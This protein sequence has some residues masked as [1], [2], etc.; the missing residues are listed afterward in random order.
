MTTTLPTIKSF[1]CG[2][3]DEGENTELNI[4]IS[5]PDAL[6]ATSV[7]GHIAILC[8]Q[9][10]QAGRVPTQVSTGEPVPAAAPASTGPVDE[11]PLTGPSAA[12]VSTPS[13]DAKPAK[14]APSAVTTTRRTA[15]KTKAPAKKASP[16]KGGA[17][18]EAEAKAATKPA[19][20]AVPDKPAAAEPVAKAADPKVA[21]D[22]VDVPDEVKTAESFSKV[23]MWMAQNVGQ[24]FDAITARVQQ[25]RSQSPAIQRIDTD[26]AKVRERVERG[27]TVLISRGALKAA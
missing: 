27:I 5:V 8:A 17:V 18:S 21:T 7:V 23:L 26:T 15:A 20:T 16:N 3:D 2:T 13:T 24:D 6:T 12:A 25:Y 14:A 1:L 22:G 4:C 19:V 9:Y 11:S 10:S